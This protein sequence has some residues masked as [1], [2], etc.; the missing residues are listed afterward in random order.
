MAPQ[1]ILL[2]GLIVIICYVSACIITDFDND[3]LTSKEVKS[4]FKEYVI[5][6]NPTK[7]QIYEQVLGI[8]ELDMSN[9]YKQVEFLAVGKYFIYDGEFII[10]SGSFQISENNNIYA[11]KT[12]PESDDINGIINI[13]SSYIYNE[14][15][16]KIWVRRW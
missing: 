14:T 2:A 1:K 8:W 12:I 16:D 7:Y 9:Q 4:C 3:T 15:T 5:T 6:N 10:H 13:C 11:I